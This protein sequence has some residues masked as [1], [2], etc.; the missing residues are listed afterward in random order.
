MRPSKSIQD[1]LK[2]IFTIKSALQIRWPGNSEFFS[3]LY[4][5]IWAAFKIMH[6]SQQPEM[7]P[8]LTLWGVAGNCLSKLQKHSGQ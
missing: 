5:R 4:H 1:I 6:D 2:Y 3:P 7:K 8:S